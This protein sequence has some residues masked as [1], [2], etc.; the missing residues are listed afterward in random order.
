MEQGVDGEEFVGVH[1]RVCLVLICCL[2]FICN[3]PFN[4]LDHGG[5]QGEAKMQR[6]K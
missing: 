4:Y 6:E 1:W 5:C 2:V 3:L